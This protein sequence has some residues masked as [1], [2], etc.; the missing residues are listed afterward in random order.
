MTAWLNRIYCE[1]VLQGIS[2]IPDGTIDLL[3]ADPPYGLGK[4]YGND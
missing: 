2:R 1:D 4:D 3:I